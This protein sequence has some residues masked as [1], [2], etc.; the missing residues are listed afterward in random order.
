M[1]T[2]C[3]VIGIG[4]VTR[5]LVQAGVKRVLA[6]E[7]IEEFLPSMLVTIYFETVHQTLAYLKL[8]LLNKNREIKNDGK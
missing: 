7:A 2:L 3:S 5:K 4:L 1:P 6:V 8:V